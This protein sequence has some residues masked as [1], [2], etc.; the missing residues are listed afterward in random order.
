MESIK[1]VYLELYHHLTENGYDETEAKTVAG[2]L[3]EDILHIKNVQSAEPLSEVQ[4]ILIQNVFERVGEGEPWQYISGKI[5][6]YGMPFVINKN[7]LIPRPE[8]EEL[9]RICLESIPKNKKVNILDVGTGSGVIAVSLAYKRPDCIVTGIDI[10]EEALKVAEENRQNMK[11]GNVHFQQQDFLTSDFTNLKQEFDFII[12]NPP[13]ITEEEKN[14][15]TSST[16]RFEPLIALF[17]NQGA[18]EFYNRISELALMQR[19]P[20]KIFT[21]VNE[22]RAKQVYNLYIQKGL[23]EVRIIQDMQGKDRMVSAVKN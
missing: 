6:F 14:I 17:V 8:T 10:S 13:Y 1:E 19:C 18:M 20:V 16:L 22:F 21:E 4:N 7:V 3:F 15:M 12:S 11:I 23:K 2:Y 9:V 5:N